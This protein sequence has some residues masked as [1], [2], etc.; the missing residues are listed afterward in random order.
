M[1]S[2][3]PRQLPH[4]TWGP[5]LPRAWCPP[6]PEADQQ[7]P[8]GWMQQHWGGS[9]LSLGGC[10]HRAASWAGKGSLVQIAG[11][12]QQVRSGGCS[13]QGRSDKLSWGACVF[14][15]F[16]GLTAGQASPG[17]SLSKYIYLPKVFPAQLGASLWKYRRAQ[18]SQTCC[19]CSGD[20]VPC[21]AEHG[22]FRSK[23]SHGQGDREPGLLCLVTNYLGAPW[24][25][26]SPP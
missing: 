2:P 23:S 25:S 20:A 24:A 6:T 18:E 7:C 19:G 22:L 13:Q 8:E 4:Q 14:L 10:P 17:P 11:E 16:L 1:E 12:G 21:G 15:P 3:A 5:W 26:H 9:A